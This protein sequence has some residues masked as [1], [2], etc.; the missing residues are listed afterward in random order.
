MLSVVVVARNEADRIGRCLR[1]IGGDIE[2]IVVLDASTTDDTARVAAREGAR[3]VERPW[4][5]HVAQKNHALGL[6]TR[7]WILSLDADE[8]L[9]DAAATEVWAALDRTDVDGFSFPR[10]SDWLGRPIRSGR[11]YPDRKLRLVRA[12]RGRWI[13]DDPHDRLIVDGPVARLRGEIRHQPYRTV[14]EH[15]STIDRYTR[16]SARTLHARGVRARRRDVWVRP[17]LQ[18]VDSMTRKMA[19]RDGLDGL[20]VAALG[21]GYVHLKWSR[22]RALGASVGRTGGPGPDRRGS[23]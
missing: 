18:F 8:W 14:W 6:A 12:G 10:C 22:L 7:P 16:I 13:G 1:S 11:W 21:A 3:V 19:W 2:R 20:A 4:P 23:R 9:T 15:L 5:G 17:A